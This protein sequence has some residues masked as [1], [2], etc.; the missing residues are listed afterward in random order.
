MQRLRAK[1]AEWAEQNH[2]DQLQDGLRCW[3]GSRTPNQD[4]VQE[5]LLFALVAANA[6][7]DSL[8]ELY[9]N[10]QSNLARFERDT[11]AVWDKVVFSVFEMVS[12]DEG[13]GFTARDIL[14]Q[15]THEVREHTASKTLQPGDWVAGFI[16]PISGLYELEGSIAV[17]F[18]DARTAAQSALSGELD[19]DSATPKRTRQAA[20]S[21]IRAVRDIEQSA[22]SSR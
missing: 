13:E 16:K 20:M 4:N 15:N 3:L 21:V 8:L 12:V 18:G 19:A 10:S 6:S 17:L 22:T 7:G 5:A 11:F 2:L 9:Q 1:V 14:T